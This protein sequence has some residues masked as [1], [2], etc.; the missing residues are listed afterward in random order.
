MYE[1]V[2]PFFAVALPAEREREIDVY[3]YIYT[4]TRIRKREKRERAYASNNGQW[5][6][7]VRA[8]EDSVRATCNQRY[9]V[10]RL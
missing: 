9:D 6:R 1:R 10:Y 8:Q 2:L 7:V 5:K 3:I 4:H